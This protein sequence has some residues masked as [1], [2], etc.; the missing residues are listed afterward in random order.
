MRTHTHT[1]LRGLA[2]TD[3]MKNKS[4]EIPVPVAPALSLPWSLVKSSLLSSQGATPQRLVTAVGSSICL[5]LSAQLM[6][7]KT[8]L[9]CH[10]L[11]PHCSQAMVSWHLEMVKWES[12]WSE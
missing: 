1:K 11:E 9:Q 10:T 5:G 7:K 12:G 4:V 8:V 6:E 2:L 3:N